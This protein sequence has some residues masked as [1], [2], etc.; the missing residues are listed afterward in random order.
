MVLTV[1]KLADDLVLAQTLLCLLLVLRTLQ[2]DITT[3]WRASLRVDEEVG[4]LL[5]KGR[6]VLLFFTQCLGHGGVELRTLRVQDLALTV[7]VLDRARSDLDA[8]LVHTVRLELQAVLMVLMMGRLLLGGGHDSALVA[9]MISILHL[10]HALLIVDQDTVDST[11]A[12]ALILG[13]A[14]HLV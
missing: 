4:V 7:G 2:A 6:M 5:D 3:A 10:C 14:A 1:A 8:A 12:T 13:E 9:T 11:L